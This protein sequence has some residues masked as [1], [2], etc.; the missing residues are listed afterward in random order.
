MFF[1]LLAAAILCDDERN[2]E[3]AFAVHSR[4][5]QWVFEEADD[6]GNEI[7]CEDPECEFYV[8]Y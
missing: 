1:E 2:E 4:R 6:L 8:E 7:C 5:D 3:N